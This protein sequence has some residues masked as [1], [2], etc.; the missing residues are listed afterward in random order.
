MGARIAHIEAGL[1]SY[2]RGMAEEINRVV[3]DHL[4]DVPTASAMDNLREEGLHQRAL[5]TGDVMYEAALMYC[6]VPPDCRSAAAELWL[7][8]A[9]PGLRARYGSSRR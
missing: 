7:A 4:S 1:R 8:I 2:R 9:S 3:T 5:L 6:D